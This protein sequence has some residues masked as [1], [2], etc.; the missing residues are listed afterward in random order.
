MQSKLEVIRS[1]DLSKQSDEDL[2][3]YGSYINKVLNGNFTGSE[4]IRKN[5]QIEL[6]YIIREAEYRRNK[7]RKQA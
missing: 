5:L 6:C 7:I 4:E 3:G 2:V 1:L